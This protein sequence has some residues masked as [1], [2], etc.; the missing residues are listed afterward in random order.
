M[1]YDKARVEFINYVTPYDKARVYYADSCH[2]PKFTLL[3]F[4]RHLIRVPITPTY[5]HYFI[6][7]LAL[8]S[9]TKGMLHEL[10]A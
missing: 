9:K 8:T 3:P 4:N 2:T 1:S 7:I 5:I 6:T 10:K